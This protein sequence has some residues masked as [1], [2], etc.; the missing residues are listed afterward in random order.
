MELVNGHEFFLAVSSR[1]ALS[2]LDASF[3]FARAS[4]LVSGEP[5]STVHLEQRAI[6]RILCFLRSEWSLRWLDACICTDASEKMLRV[7]GS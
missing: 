7:R 4:H 2:I 6:G 5:W 3:K 1:G